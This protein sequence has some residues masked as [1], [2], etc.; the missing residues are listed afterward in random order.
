MTTLQRITVPMINAI[1]ITLCLLYLMFL[2]I[3]SDEPEL[4]LVERRELPP[5][6]YVDEESQ[7]IQKFTRPAKV[8]DVDEKPAPLIDDT[9]IN[10]A[11]I[12]GI[13]GIAYRPPMGVETISNVIDNQLV[14]ALQY[15]PQYPA[16]AIAREIEGFV[17]VGFSVNEVGAVYSPY[18]IESEPGKVFDK[19]ALKAIS[20]FRYK[21]RV[22]GGKTVSTD[23]QRYMFTFRL[24]D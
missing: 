3:K 22:I 6:V 1:F 17:V 4:K 23:G 14:L 9:P 19:S 24:D 13:T 5:I 8:I 18:I 7:L 21:A 12:E 20:K 15:P 10:I 11:S 2:L 16:G